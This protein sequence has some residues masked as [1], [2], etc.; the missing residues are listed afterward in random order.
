MLVIILHKHI[1]AKRPF[2]KVQSINFACLSMSV[3]NIL[4]KVWRVRI[5][6]DLEINL[7]YSTRFSL[8]DVREY[9]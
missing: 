9:L 5:I 6:Y 8:K 1:H 3:V 7:Q 2:V 4:A